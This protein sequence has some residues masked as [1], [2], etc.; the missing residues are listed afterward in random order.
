MKKIL[1]MIISSLF[2]FSCF[3]NSEQLK[4]K[5][6][7]FRTAGKYYVYYNGNTMEL[8]ADLYIKSNKK[9]ESYYSKGFLK[10]I[11]IDVMNKSE[12]LNDLDKYFP[13]GIEYITSG[14]NVSKTIISIPLTKVDGKQYIDSVKFEKFLAT[15]PK[16]N[17]LSNKS[18]EDQILNATNLLKNKKLAILNASEI[19]GFA[20]KI[21]DDLTQK[22]G[23]TYIAE[24]YT[25]K[26]SMNYVINHTLSPSEVSKLIE[27]LNLKY[28]KILD[29][30]SIKPESDFVIITGDEANIEFPIEIITN[31]AD[32][33]SKVVT[34]LNGYV[35][36][37]K[38]AEEYKGQKISD[39]KEV[40][41]YYNPF[42]VY[43][44]QKI[45]K[46]LVNAKLIEDS[47]I[48]DKMIIVTSK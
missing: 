28:I 16:K 2:L 27:T 20:K 44:A 17:E 19:D 47:T 8:P 31:I 1:L 43:T 7:I 13:D 40:E 33:N 37:K 34:L 30:P 32:D 42:D 21:G 46:I 36:Q 6:R 48:K 22:L 45:A 11:G 25:K 24:N 12:L 15:L 5:N 4:N 35:L 9:L 18:Q 3:D 39:K 38:Q 10:N 14:E 23:I 26:E 29:D 41:I